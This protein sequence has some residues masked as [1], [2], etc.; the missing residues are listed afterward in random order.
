MGFGGQVGVDVGRIGQRFN[1]FGYG[2]AVGWGVGCHLGITR[3]RF[4]C[5]NYNSTLKRTFNTRM[6]VTIMDNLYRCFRLR[7]DGLRWVYVI[8]PR[9]TAYPHMLKKMQTFYG[10]RDGQW[11]ATDLTPLK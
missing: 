5:F 3:H 7:L 4:H 1:P 10:K 8:A 9:R 6:V 11:R 2:M